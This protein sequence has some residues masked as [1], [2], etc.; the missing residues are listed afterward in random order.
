MDQALATLPTLRHAMLRPGVRVTRR[1]GTHLQVG[2]D[3]RTALV[4]PD[5]SDTRAMLSALRSGGPIDHETRASDV[6]RALERRGQIVDADAYF[7]HLPA[8][9]QHQRARAALFAQHPRDAAWRL[10]ARA[11]A[12]VAVDADQLGAIAVHLL[13][14]A[15]LGQGGGRPT[16]G[17]LIADGEVRR[18]RL[19][20]LMQTSTPHL[21]ISQSDGI[22]R[23]GPFVDPGR[24]A[25]QRCI[26]AQ[27]GEQDPRRGLIIEQYAEET[28][29]TAVAE[30]HD[31][32]FLLLAVSLAVADVVAFVDGD[33][34]ATWSTTIEV[35][36]GLELPRTLWKRHPR[37]GCSWA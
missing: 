4:V 25:C 19:D 27:L 28:V 10:A 11:A 13:T 21:L 17:L 5:S 24:T 18:P 36:P 7:H 3:P 31:E 8:D 14:T 1:D 12:H 2:L 26:D 34:P 9:Q 37:C 20:V 35:G 6:W 23:V 15:G 16:V 32:T 30:P 22:V 33:R 29:P